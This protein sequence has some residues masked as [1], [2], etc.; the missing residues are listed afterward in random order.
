LSQEIPEKYLNTRY[1]RIFVWCHETLTLLILIFAL[2]V[3]KSQLW[4]HF[5]CRVNFQITRHFMDLW[6]RRSRNIC[7]KL[8]KIL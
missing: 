4:Q 3:L 8:Y 7:G 1:L 2:V 6:V 5:K